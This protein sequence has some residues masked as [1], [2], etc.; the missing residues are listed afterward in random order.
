MYLKTF[1]G[2]IY[3]DL[4]RIRQILLS[5][6]FTQMTQDKMILQLCSGARPYLT[7]SKMF[8]L[9]HWTKKSGSLVFKCLG[10]MRNGS[11]EKERVVRKLVNVIL[12]HPRP[13][14][15]VSSTERLR[16]HPRPFPVVSFT[17]RLRPQPTILVNQPHIDI[18]NTDS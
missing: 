12:L 14:P 13:F 1:N 7:D 16:P 18:S 8:S 2:T 10:L 17:E 15:A 4:I 3:F 5:V 11:F 6:I 9:R